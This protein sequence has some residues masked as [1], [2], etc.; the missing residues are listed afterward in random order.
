MSPSRHPSSQCIHWLEDSISGLAA[1][2]LVRRSWT[3]IAQY[4]LFKDISLLRTNGRCGRL[5]DILSV[6]PHIIG[7]IQSLA[8]STQ[9][10]SADDFAVLAALACPLSYGTVSGLKQLFALPRLYRV[11][12]R[13][14]F[15]DPHIFASL[16][17]E[18]SPS[19]KELF[20]ICPPD[21]QYVVLPPPLP[22]SQNA[23]T[24]TL[25]KIRPE[26]LTL[27]AYSRLSCW[28]NQDQAAFDMSRLRTL[29]ICLNAAHNLGPN[30]FSAKSDSLEALYIDGDYP[31]AISFAT[32][33]QYRRLGVIHMRRVP[34]N[35]LEEV[36]DTISKITREYRTQDIVIDSVGTCRTASFWPHTNA[37][38]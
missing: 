26:S 1:C 6:S 14:A 5:L 12:L 18:A 31:M 28:L 37:R 36:Q 25:R 19:I 2:A 24:K 11:H 17:E 3:T 38:C 16:W 33:S 35:E 13:C 34:K 8:I 27:G 7:F 23:T 9:T 21:P 15:G 32:Y 29:D 4:H 30:S 10:F 20:L 22:L